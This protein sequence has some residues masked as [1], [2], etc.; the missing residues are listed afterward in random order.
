MASLW[1]VFWAFPIQA[2]EKKKVTYT[3]KIKQQISRQDVYPNDV[4]N[5]QISQTVRISSISHSDRDF[6]DTENWEYGQSDSVAG[7]G[8]H[9]GYSVVNYTNGDKTY[10]KWEGTHQ[11][12]MKEGGAWETSYE[13]KFHITGGT[14]KFKNIRGQ[15]SYRGTH[16][17]KGLTEEGEFEA[18]Y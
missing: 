13:G 6:G 4:P 3:K 16:T 7:S 11:T 15:G 10:T 9:R 12:S 18:E 14:G 5:H 1:V 8:S 2:G 17:A